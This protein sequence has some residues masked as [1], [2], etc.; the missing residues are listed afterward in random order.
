MLANW[1]MCDTKFCWHI[2]DLV[3][4]CQINFHVST[5]QSHHFC[6]CQH[7]QLQ[8]GRHVQLRCVLRR[9]PVIEARPLLVL[10]PGAKSAPALCTET[11]VAIVHAAPDPMTTVAAEQE[12][13]P[14]SSVSSVG[15]QFGTSHPSEATTATMREHHSLQYRYQ[16]SLAHAAKLRAD[17]KL[18]R[19]ELLKMCKAYHKA[20]AWK[21][22]LPADVVAFLEEQIAAGSKKKG[23]HR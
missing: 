13:L 16:R 17:L 22:E 19:A 11:T 7:P 4:Y 15:V 2:Y 1:E 5:S 21:D 23:G 6:Q 12:V 3:I 10:A 8:C 9:C 18:S 20:V 14:L